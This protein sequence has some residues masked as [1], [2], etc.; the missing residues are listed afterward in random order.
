M[1][2]QE[3]PWRP[4]GEDTEFSLP[5]L[6]VQSLVRELKSHKQY[7]APPPKKKEHPEFAVLELAFPLRRLPW[8]LS[9]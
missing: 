5:R 4:G 7:S 8:W 9:W 6:C 2:I 1:I 3:I